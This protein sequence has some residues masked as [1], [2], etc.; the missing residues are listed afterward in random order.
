M[1]INQAFMEMFSTIVQLSGL[2]MFGFAGQQIYQHYKKDEEK[3]QSE[4]KLSKVMENAKMYEKDSNGNM[5]YPR[6]RN[7]K[8]QDYG[9]D[10]AYTIPYGQDVSEWKKQKG[11]I[12]TAL[13]KEVEFE[14]EGRKLTMKVLDTVL[15]DE[16]TYNTNILDDIIGLLEVPI[17]YT[18]K[19]F[20]T[21]DIADKQMHILI[22]G[23]S[24]AGK[25]VTIRNMLTTLILKYPVNYFRLRLI[26]LKIVELS[27]FKHTPYC[28]SYSTTHEETLDTL[29]EL[30][31]EMEY[32]YNVINQEPN[33]K[34]INDLDGNMPYQ[35]VVIDEYAELSPKMLAGEEK[36]IA[37]EIQSKLGTLFRRGRAAGVFFIICTQRPDSKVVDGQIKANTQVKICHRVSDKVN[38]RI[39]LDNNFA[40]ELDDTPGRGIFKINDNIKFQAPY[41]SPEHA[42]KLI[43]EKCKQINP[44]DDNDKVVNLD[45]HREK[46]GVIL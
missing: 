13:E 16:Y 39:V 44:E 42:T 14:V 10:M 8:E 17:G 33:A 27:T 34:S 35:L 43:N 9:Y 40:A 37:K 7:I 41:L 6:I 38:S 21:L 24:G 2:S 12:E 1:P 32:R 28:E 45:E 20:L 11:K 30:Q 22:A 19:K 36:K 3:H 23:Y 29:L 4:I 46:K 26:D 25:S 31:N 15:K 5:H 18:K